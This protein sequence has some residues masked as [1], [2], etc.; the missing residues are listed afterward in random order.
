MVVEKYTQGHSCFLARRMWVQ[1]P[2]RPPQQAFVCW[3]QRSTY[4]ITHPSPTSPDQ[5]NDISSRPFSQICLFLFD[6]TSTTPS[7]LYLKCWNRCSNLHPLL[8]IQS[9]PP[10][11]PPL[12]PALQCFTALFKSR[13]ESACR[14]QPSITSPA[15]QSCSWR[16]YYD[17]GQT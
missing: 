15:H 14:S 12:P 1:F 11:L 7:L 4:G 13:A 5:P 9:V 16:L 17:G 6:L 2:P 10:P 8:N 3:I